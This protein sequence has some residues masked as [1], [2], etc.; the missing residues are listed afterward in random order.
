[1]PFVVKMIS[2]F[3]D[4]GQGLYGSLPLGD[5]EDMIQMIKIWNKLNIATRQDPNSLIKVAEWETAGAHPQRTAE[6][7]KR[8]FLLQYLRMALE[9][10]E[11]GQRPLLRGSNVVG[12]KP[13]HENDLRFMLTQMAKNVAHPKMAGDVE[14]RMRG[15]IF[16]SQGDTRELVLSVNT[17]SDLR[18]GPDKYRV[19]AECA[20]PFSKKNVLIDGKQY[21]IY[22]DEYYLK[23][24]KETYE[25]LVQSGLPMHLCCISLKDMVGQL[26]PDSALSLLPAIITTVRLLQQEWQEKL[27]IEK[28][29]PTLIIP[30]IPI[31]LHLHD[32]GFAEETSAIAIEICKKMD[33]AVI[34]DAVECDPLTNDLVGENAWRNTGFPSL[35][36]II[37][38]CKAKG[39]E[40][41]FDPYMSDLNELGRLG[42]V[43]AQKYIGRR[44]D[45]SLLGT[46]LRVFDVPGGGIASCCMAIASV[47]IKGISDIGLAQIL[48]LTD[49]EAFALVGFALL[50]VAESAGY[51]HAV[52]PGFQN[53]Q[54]MAINFI[55][56]L[57]ITNQLIPGMPLY[58]MMAKVRKKPVN[59]QHKDLSVDEL[60][61][62]IEI[63]TVGGRLSEEA[64]QELLLWNLRDVP[65][66]FFKSKSPAEMMQE[67]GIA[68]PATIHPALRKELP[69]RTVLLTQT[70]KEPLLPSIIKVVERLYTEGL[71]IPTDT[72]QQMADIIFDHLS[73]SERQ[74]KAIEI[75]K[76]SHIVWGLLVGGVEL[77]NA[78]RKPWLAEPNPADYPD[79][80]DGYLFAM[81][82]TKQGK[83]S[84]PDELGQQYLQIRQGERTVGPLY[85]HTQL[86]LAQEQTQI[87]MSVLMMMQK[88]PKVM[89]DLS[90]IGTVTHEIYAD[91]EKTIQAKQERGGRF[92]FSRRRRLNMA[93]DFFATELEK[94]KVFSLAQIKETIKEQR[95]KIEGN[96]ILAPSPGEV[97]EVFVKA[98]DRVEKD[99]RL[100]TVTAMKT[101]MD[102][103]APKA[104]IIEEIVGDGI[105]IVANQKLIVFI[106][107]QDKNEVVVDKQ[108]DT[109]TTGFTQAIANRMKNIE[110]EQT[111][112][113][114]QLQRSTQVV[115]ND[116]QPQ[117]SKTTLTELE[118]CGY[119]CRPLT[120]TEYAKN[121]QNRD[122]EIHIINNRSVPAL[123][124]YAHLKQANHTIRLLYTKADQHSN[125]VKFLKKNRPEELIFV[126]SYTHIRG[127]LNT[128]KKVATENPDATV[129]IHPVWGLLAEVVEFVAEI[130]KLQTQGFKIKFVG[131]PSHAMTLGDKGA[132]RDLM[133]EVS[134]LS[135][136]PYFR[137]KNYSAAA[138]KSYMQDFRKG[139]EIDTDLRD[140][141]NR[142]KAMREKDKENKVVIKADAGG[143][144]MGIKF[145]TVD[146]NLSDEK[147]YE[148]FVALL[149]ENVVDSEKMF[150]SGAMVI[151]QCITGVTWHLEIQIM[152]ND[153]G[154][155]IFGARTCTPQSRGQK[156]N[157]ANAT[158]AD[159]TRDQM[160]AVLI[161]AKKIA[162]KLWKRGY[163]GLGTLEFLILVDKMAK[164]QELK[165]Q[166]KAITQQ[167]NFFIGLELNPRLQV[168]HAV[169]QEKAYLQSKDEKISMSLPL[170]LLACMRAEG[171]HLYQIMNRDFGMSDSA[172]MAAN[173]LTDER[174]DHIRINSQEIDLVR[175]GKPVP[176]YWWGVLWP[177]PK[178]MAEMAKRTGVQMVIGEIGD[179]T[180]VSHTGTI[181]GTPAQVL[182][183][184]EE[185]KRFVELARICMDHDGT[186][187]LGYVLAFHQLIYHPQ[188]GSF[189]YNIGTKTQDEIFKMIE[190]G[191]LNTDPYLDHQALTLTDTFKPEGIKEMFTEYLNINAR[192][193]QDLQNRKKMV[194]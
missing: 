129:W 97:T 184:G 7:E 37:A 126:E 3:R 137:L 164:W 84:V 2:D 125:F 120:L 80:I 78:L 155:L 112:L 1:M 81:R 138:L 25:L 119:Y 158:K 10:R 148:A 111:R 65:K 170:M 133:A 44:A 26:D 149:T 109:D 8:N 95:K 82:R 86:L 169:T 139:S 136:P 135:N 41:G 12:L 101:P 152:V 98:G 49:S 166:N 132:Y 161:E 58:I 108:D 17:L 123:V 66:T 24:V 28:N 46:A 48:K 147:N 50:T 40:L 121:P 45:F 182:A 22:P 116:H 176:S 64:V 71:I 72:Q 74:E 42:K 61:Q 39:I 19:S 43:V 128:A 175:G 122:K 178:I 54:H 21:S 6:F 4:F 103:Y 91:Q 70:V 106:A 168:E 140:Y 38:R 11:T 34:L 53:K 165:Q 92:F 156:T 60:I 14:D 114:Y 167:N 185:I 63:E 144:G 193:A 77:E 163:R 90:S 127:I 15:R 36:G 187:N 94:L 162:Q 93:L 179:G 20:I 27:R 47:K 75:A 104:G 73:D 189:M 150:K 105:P 154:V 153:K 9:A 13:F 102:I 160:H 67:W 56:N 181:W 117:T 83:N 85:D 88:F 188:S 183:V 5:D 177:H 99:Q 68:T 59:E 171:L 191:R 190:D 118:Q 157:E 115:N 89:N 32:T 174:V 130:E 146:D 107:P 57:I 18:N 192:E 96:V 145:Y 151:E 124:T 142:I 172:V 33:Y 87:R 113:G 159:Y 35:R 23:K 173:M 69:L 55:T 131:P 51:T 16:D 100:M 194:N 186:V 141:F 31:G 76:D 180:F 134:P 110:E 30:E 79:D 29:D 62:A 143:G 52:T